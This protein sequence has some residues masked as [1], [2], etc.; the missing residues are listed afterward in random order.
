MTGR[1]GWPLTIVMTAEKKPFFAGTYF[2][3]ESRAG[4]P[5]LMDILRQILT[6]WH[7]SQDELYQAAEEITRLARPGPSSLRAIRI[8]CF[9]TGDFGNSR[10]TSI[11]RMAGLAA[12][13][14]SRPPTS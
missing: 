8:A 9:S 1:G 7:G 12:H 6:L 14:N 4:M 3:K 2:P 10:H 5:G 11:R 13:R